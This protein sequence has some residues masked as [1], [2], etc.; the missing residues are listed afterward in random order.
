MKAWKPGCTVQS[1]V[2]LV[3]DCRGGMPGRLIPVL[4]NELPVEIPHTVD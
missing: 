2:T 1:E 3:V 4:H